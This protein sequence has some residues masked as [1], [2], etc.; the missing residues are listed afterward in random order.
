MAAQ[1]TRSLRLMKSVDALRGKWYSFFH[2]ATGRMPIAGVQPML[3]QRIRKAFLLK[4]PAIKSDL[5]ADT[6]RKVFPEMPLLHCN[7]EF[8]FECFTYKEFNELTGEL[9][10][11]V[12]RSQLAKLNTNKVTILHDVREV[13]P[14][15]PEAF[16]SW[17]MIKEIR[18]RS[19]KRFEITAEKKVPPYIAQFG[20]Q[21]TG[22]VESSLRGYHTSRTEGYVQ[23]GDIDPSYPTFGCELEFIPNANYRLAAESRASSYS[24]RRLAGA[25]EVASRILATCSDILDIENDGS[26]PSGF[27]I[28]SGYGHFDALDAAMRKLYKLHIEKGLLQTS[29][30]TGL[31]FHVGW[32]P[33]THSYLAKLCAFVSRYR[34]LIVLVAGRSPN[35]YCR[36]NNFHIKRGTVE[37]VDAP[38]WTACA[39]PV[40]RYNAINTQVWD[41]S[42][43]P[44][45]FE[46][47]SPKATI[48]YATWRARL[49]FI[50]HLTTWIGKH[51]ETDELQPLDEFISYV[52]AHPK[53]CTVGLRRLLSSAAGQT[54]LVGGLGVRVPVCYNSR[55]E[56]SLLKL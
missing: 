24:R 29:N 46:W 39:L 45:R 31:H 12:S 11:Y 20:D 41:A 50:C 13:Y 56:Y 23:L 16:E 25:Y 34:Q 54:L 3:E 7:D 33:I 10:N 43:I 26:V 8:E 37:G 9:S 2:H 6:Y 5:M 28:V 47:R 27:E 1:L 52:M 15:P 4:Q 14:V 48:S 30:R 17:P 38:A 49:E 35:R 21:V 32:E 40:D 19:Y 22:N 18:V 42:D 36:I 44:P 51:Q 55:S 53:E